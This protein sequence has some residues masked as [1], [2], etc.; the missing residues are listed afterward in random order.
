[1]NLQSLYELIR[2]RKL[3]MPPNSYTTRLFESG[4]DE[5]IKKF[6]EESIEVVLAASRQGRERLVEELSDL[7]YHA[8]VMMVELGISPQDINSELEKRHR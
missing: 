6:G 5:I 3:E 1:M 2:S 7:V 4:P 8:L